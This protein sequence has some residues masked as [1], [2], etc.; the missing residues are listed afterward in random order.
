MSEE[1]AKYRTDKESSLSE[2]DK[3]TIQLFEM[4]VITAEKFLESMESKLDCSHQ[5]DLLCG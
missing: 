2:E 5:I 1:T 4:G 3:W